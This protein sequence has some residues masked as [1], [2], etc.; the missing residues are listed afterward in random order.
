MANYVVK[1][2]FFS[3]RLYE[4]GTQV[5]LDKDS[6]GKFADYVTCLDKSEEPAQEKPKTVTTEKKTGGSKKK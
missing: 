6:A 5:Q 1:Q 3:G 4:K 2:T